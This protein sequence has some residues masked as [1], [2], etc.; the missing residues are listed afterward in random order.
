M[1]SL[2]KT[3][4]KKPAIAKPMLL[5]ITQSSLVTESWISA[6]SFQET[7]R[8]LSEAA[9]AGQADY[10]YGLK[11]NVIVGKLIPAGTGIVSFR[12]KYLGHEVS[13][14]ERQAQKEEHSSLHRADTPK[15]E[16]HAA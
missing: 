10:L 4:G 1:N 12:D 9:I 8:I 14:L 2:L 6:A 15:S 3:E 5:G 13:D 7:T 16:M 11:E